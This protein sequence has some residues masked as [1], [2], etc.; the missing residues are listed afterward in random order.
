MISGDLELLC[1]ALSIREKERPVGTLDANLIEKGERVLALCL[2]SKVLTTK[3]VNKEAFINVMTSIWRVNERVDIEALEGNVFAFHFKNLADKRLVQS[4]GPWTFDRAL[5]TLEEPTGT[6]DIAHMKFSTIEIWVQIHNL[7]LMCMTE[8]IGVFLG[9]MIGEVK[10]V[11]RSMN[12]TNLERAK[13][14]QLRQSPPKRFDHR[15]KPFERQSWGYQSG[16]SYNRAAQGNWR[17]RTQWK[18]LGKKSLESLSGGRHLNVNKEKNLMGQVH[19]LENDSKESSQV[20]VVQCL[21]PYKNLMGKDAAINALGGRHG[22]RRQ[23]QGNLFVRARLVIQTNTSVPNPLVNPT[24]S[25]TPIK[26]IHTTAKWKRAARTK[27]DISVLGANSSL[28]KRGSIDRREGSQSAIKRV[29]GGIM[30]CEISSIQADEQVRV[31]EFS[32]FSLG[33]D[34]EKVVGAADLEVQVQEDSQQSVLQSENLSSEDLGLIY[35]L[36]FPR[37]LLSSVPMV[38]N[39][40]PP[41]QNP[42]KIN[43]RAVTNFANRSTGLGIII[44]NHSGDILSSCSFFQDS[45]MDFMSANAVAILKGYQLGKDCGLSFFCVESDTV[46]VVNLVNF[47]NH[48]NSGC[49]NIVSDILDIMLEMG[50]SSVLAGKKGTNKLTVTL[51]RQALSRKSNLVWRRPRR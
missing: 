11:T 17:S 29:K 46:N 4:G 30:E 50:H 1:S 8:D 48:A 45:G 2:V 21:E 37:L 36:R 43:C 33:L 24:S 10:E 31:S 15:N 16:S 47:G 7:P 42:F 6:G 13:R 5:T 41:I 3:V 27:G 39:W 22:I 51:A 23:R 9:T 35:Q 34:N 18:G 44:R 49:G 19:C 28:G 26:K 20:G 40:S 14:L 25:G 38:S 12:A 32:N